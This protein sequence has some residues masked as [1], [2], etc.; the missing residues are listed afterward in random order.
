MRPFRTAMCK[1]EKG[2][3]RKT[4]TPAAQGSLAIHRR[5]LSEEGFR[6]GFVRVGGNR[7]LRAQGSGSSTQARSAGR[8]S[9]RMLSVA[10]RGNAQTSR[11]RCRKFILWKLCQKM[12]IAKLLR[13]NNFT[14]A[15]IRSMPFQRQVRV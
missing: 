9:F 4:K 6:E 2:Q 13:P 11:V 1:H 7:S 14:A 5:L 8:R 3:R 10:C 12:G 15:E